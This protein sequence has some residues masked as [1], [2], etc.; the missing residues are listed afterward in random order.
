MTGGLTGGDFLVGGFVLTGGVED[1]L[2]RLGGLS[3]G[4]CYYSTIVGEGGGI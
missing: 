4:F 3:M 2:V 1:W